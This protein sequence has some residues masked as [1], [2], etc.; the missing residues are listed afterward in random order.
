MYV[1]VYEHE[2]LIG[3]RT[4]ACICMYVCMYVCMLELVTFECMYVY[5]LRGD[6]I[7]GDA[8][9]W[10]Q[11]HPAGSAHDIQQPEDLHHGAGMYA[12]IPM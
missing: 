4:Y 5:R 8:A 11:R 1:C 3:I 2:C 6:R 10:H 7:R 9:A 12:Y